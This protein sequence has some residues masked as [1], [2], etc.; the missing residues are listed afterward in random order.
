MKSLICICAIA[1]INSNIVTTAQNSVAG[2]NSE[3]S[4]VKGLSKATV[5]SKYQAESGS[6]YIYKDGRSFE[7]KFFF[8]QVD[9]A[10]YAYNE[11]K[12]RSE[13]ETKFDVGYYSPDGEWYE[14][15]DSI[16]YLIGQ[17]DFDADDIDEL[18]IALQDNDEDGN[19][20][21]V[22]IYKLRNDKWVLIG[23]LTGKIILGEPT[24]EI[25][26]N[27]VTIPRNL[28]GFYYQWTLESGKFKDTSNI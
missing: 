1:I 25:K 3:S 8:N 26:M 5:Y 16:K 23:D 2:S 4:F 27:K 12:Q 24:A 28:R 11:N 13:I 7:I 6:V 19:G 17:Y 21:C 22:N 10:F 14:L 20:I 9:V 18:V 15:K